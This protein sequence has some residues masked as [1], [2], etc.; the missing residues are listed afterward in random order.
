M[1]FYNVC[2]TV[3]WCEQ[4]L[5]LDRDLCVYVVEFCCFL[6]KWSLLWS[7]DNTVLKGQ[8]VGN[9]LVETVLRFVEG[10]FS[11]VSIQKANKNL[12]ALLCG[13]RNETVKG[14]FRLNVSS[15]RQLNVKDSVFQ[16]SLLS[17]FLLI[18]LY[19]SSFSRFCLLFF[20][21]YI[22]LIVT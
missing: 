2:S 19:L 12:S 21:H 8:A 1:S 10:L 20:F 9:S 14:S 4:S 22:K 5:L 13:C 16:S 18:G 7:N 3:N 6:M 15:A 11:F 17:C